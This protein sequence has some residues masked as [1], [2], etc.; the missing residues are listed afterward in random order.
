MAD[1]PRISQRILDGGLGIPANTP[2]LLHVKV[3][4]CSG[5]IR[6]KAR[7]RSTVSETVAAMHAGPLVTGASHHLQ[8]AGQLWTVRTATSNN[9]TIGAV[10]KNPAGTS[11]GTMTATLSSFV[12]HAA[13]A[14]G[15][16]LAVTTGWVTL[17]IP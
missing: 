11:T 2:D 3:G 9:G 8:R 14:G 5:G 4:V 15:A 12:L 7:L 1:V 13:I 16:P 6:N 17:P 10:T